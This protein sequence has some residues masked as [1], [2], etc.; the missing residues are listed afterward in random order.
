MDLYSARIHQLNVTAGI[1]THILL[2]TP[3]LEYGKLDRSATTPHGLIISLSRLFIKV[4]LKVLIIIC[5]PA[6]RNPQKVAEPQSKIQQ[7]FDQLCVIPPSW[8]IY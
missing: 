3:E 7:I 8:V 5:D 4:I 2:L 1:R 6:R